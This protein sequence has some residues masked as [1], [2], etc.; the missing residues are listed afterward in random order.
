VLHAEPGGAGGSDC[1]DFEV[2]GG[3]REGSPIEV[4]PTR[5]YRVEEAREF[6]TAAGLD[7]DRVGP[8]IQDKFMSAFIAQKSAFCGVEPPARMPP[9]SVRSMS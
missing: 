4:E 1:G 6:L 7:A 3:R 2:L 5:I 8:Q 9:S